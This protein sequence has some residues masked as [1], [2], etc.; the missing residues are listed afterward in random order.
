MST[1][2]DTP[3]SVHDGGDFEWGATDRLNALETVMW[4]AEVD[5]ALSST[6]LA[7]EI[8]DCEPDWER[9]RAAHEWGA[10]L[11]PR[12]RQRIVDGPAGLGQPTW[13][14]DPK[15]DLDKH[16]RRVR[17]PEGATM[18][19]MFDRVRDIAQVPFDRTRSPWQAVLIEGLPDG[20]A[21]YALKLHHSTL[22]GMAGMQL[23]TG[24]HSRRR[25]PSPNKTMA[26]PPAPGN[27]SLVRAVT[28]Q[29]GRDARGVVG[30]VAGTPMRL[31]RMGRP[32][33][34]A[35]DALKYAASLR[36]VLGDSGAPPSPLLA[37]RGLDWWLGGL[38]V[39]FA[40]LRAAA[41]SCGASLNDAF[42]A[43]LLG[44]FRR[45]HEA[46]DMPVDAI[47][48][49]IPISV[50]KPDDPAGGN[51]FAAAKL[52]GPVAE[53]DPV[54]R[55]HA[56]GRQVRAVK[57]EPALNGLGQLAPALAR[58]P[59]PVI[60]QL[61]GSL[62]KAN[63][64]QASN[65]PG[66]RHDAYVAGAKVEQMYG[67][68]PLPGCAAMIV[69]LT[70]GDTC[71]VAVNLDPAAIKDPQLFGRCLVEGFQEVLDLVPGAAAPVWRG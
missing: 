33:R 32:D 65:V 7:L 11:V 30:A 20:K 37:D 10:N 69:L 4:R 28:D 57:D 14:V 23:L 25:E 27:T 18:R 15:F 35:R 38:D 5:P 40:G 67:Y 1:T 71:C 46:F 61:A 47:P 2:E 43:G 44:G 45:Y 58:L 50:R 56:I 19:D 6:V 34:A 8:L 41:K 52:A 59:G 54:K 31:L 39:E 51:A 36:R 63:D 68:A 21:A 60:A 66:L 48:M 29:A 3:A 13:V 64:L 42:V 9:F 26:P 22:D 49:A 17:L 53:T 70:H 62:T 24:L 16:V 12:F 55:M